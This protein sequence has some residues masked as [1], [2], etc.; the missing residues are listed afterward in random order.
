MP[1]NTEKAVGETGELQTH[2]CM[3]VPTS[4]LGKCEARDLGTSP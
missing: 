4:T 3:E 1:D 2:W